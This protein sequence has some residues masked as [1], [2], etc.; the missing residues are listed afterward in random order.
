MGD[1]RRKWWHLVYKAEVRHGLSKETIVKV[2]DM[3]AIVATEKKLCFDRRPKATIYIEDMA[4]FARVI[5]TTT[6][7][8]FLCGWYRV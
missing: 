8:T 7:M 5:L 3:L 2:E 6:E 1:E 4:E